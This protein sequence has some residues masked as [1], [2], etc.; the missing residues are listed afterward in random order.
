MLAPLYVHQGAD[1]TGGL[2]IFISSGFVRLM[3]GLLELKEGVE[4]GTEVGEPYNLV[5]G[6]KSLTIF[7]I[8]HKVL[9][10]LE[11]GVAKSSNKVSMASH[12][13]QGGSFRILLV[14]GRWI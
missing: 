7:P 1:G 9:F 12:K 11:F 5:K 4:D 3:G 10:Q 14:D 8:R 2:G 13:Q 6:D